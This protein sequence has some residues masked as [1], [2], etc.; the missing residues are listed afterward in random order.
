MEPRRVPAD[1]GG[2]ALLAASCLLAPS[3]TPL[4]RSLDDRCTLPD[5][6]HALEQE[7]VNPSTG[8]A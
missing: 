8:L 2:S 1:L 3:L 6:E 7:L 5:D 4:H